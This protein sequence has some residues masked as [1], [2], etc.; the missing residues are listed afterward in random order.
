MG[1]DA[2]VMCRCWQDGIT[3]PPPMPAE[4]IKF[5]A[6][7][8][9]ALVPPHND[10]PT[11]LAFDTWVRAA[12]RHPD[13]QAEVRHVSDWVGYR[14]FQDALSQSGWEHFPAL[15]EHLPQSNG[16]GWMP[17]PAAAQALDE[18]AYF[19]QGAFLGVDTSLV[20][21][22]TG[23]VVM[24]YVKAHDGVVHLATGFEAGIGPAGFFVR[25]DSRTVFES[26]RFEQ[27]ISPQGVRFV[28][29]AQAVDWPYDPIGPP[30]AKRLCV[31]TSLRTAADF[32]ST[33]EALTAVCRASVETGNPVM[34]S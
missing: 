31:T 21:E 33:V 34:W 25:L 27:V 3:T 4:W 8:Y 1:L 14:L 13:M 20:D 30:V 12:C 2:S 7:G 22:D 32:D 9:L 6:E 10:L 23:E 18:L 15:R 16:G 26:Q 19:V 28:D 29:G 11:C 17:A 5:D 24:T